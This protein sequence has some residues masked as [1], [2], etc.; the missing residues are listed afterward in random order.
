MT[1]A[2]AATLASAA[3]SLFF[4]VP[5]PVR[6]APAAA[7]SF[8]F[9]D[10][11]RIVV[12]GD[13]ITVEGGY[14]RYLENFLRTRFPKWTI[15]VRNA[16]INGEIAQ[17]GYK[18]MDRDVMVWRPTAVIVNY[19]M[20]DGRRPQGAQIYRDGIVPYV[21]KLIAHGVRVVLCS[22]TPLDIGD[23]PGVFTGYNLSFHEMAGFAA[24]LAAK[25]GIP[26]VDQFHFCHDL[27]GRNRDRPDPVPVSHQ[28]GV[29]Y[30]SDF[31]HARGPGQLTMA[32]II[33]KTLGAP[34]EVSAAAID[35]VSGRA[36]VRRCA[37]SE[38]RALPAVQGISFV[39]TD[40]ASPCWID[41]QQP[42]PGRLG[43][44]LVPFLEKLNRM[45]LQVTGLPD[46]RYSLAIDGQPQGTLSAAQ[47]A[48]GINLAAAWESPVYGPGR[49]LDAKI[50]AQRAASYA[51]RQVRFFAPPA[52][53]TVPELEAQKEREFARRREALEKLDAEI[54]PLAAPRPLRYEIRRVDDR[55][56]EL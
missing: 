5:L 26:F 47:L 15:A 19:G 18:V 28:T 22:N 36:E 11:D 16:G 31:V 54:H 50:R 38:F 45:P 34:A 32:Y 27:W 29:P 14:V 1:I 33:L 7:G 55:R 37:I 25:R 52:W 9:R 17:G 53:L 46:G 12:V 4:A 2:G 42:F 41:D 51:A 13:S 48:A 20:N 6:A 24:E 21:D 8:F 10:G 35:A 43:L 49:A 56:G 3:F 44:K 23:R 39:R 40:E 30:P